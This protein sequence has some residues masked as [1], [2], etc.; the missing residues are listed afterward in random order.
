MTR[1]RLQR[2]IEMARLSGFFKVALEETD[3]AR[4]GPSLRTQLE[5]RKTEIDAMLEQIVIEE[6][7]P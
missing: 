4:V 7:A 1:E 2:V 3:P 5:V 6:T